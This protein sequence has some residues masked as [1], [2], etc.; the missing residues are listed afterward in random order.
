MASHTIRG[1]TIGAGL[2]GRQRSHSFISVED[3]CLKYVCDAQRAAG[4]KLANKV[5]T[6]QGQP[7]EWV[8]DYGAL[9]S[10]DIDL[11]FVAVPHNIAAE[12]V[13]RLLQNGINV[14]MEKPMG[15]NPSAYLCCYSKKRNVL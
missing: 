10:R 15:I 3:T 13:M 4:I 2:I 5:T 12:I 1:A 9:L 8:Q 7:C 14:L 11:A 6:L